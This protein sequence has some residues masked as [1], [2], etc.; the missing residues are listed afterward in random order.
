VARFERGGAVKAGTLEAIQRTLEK[1]GVIYMACSAGGAIKIKSASTS[2]TPA[3]ILR[4]QPVR[5]VG[6]HLVDVTVQ[7]VRHEN[8]PF[9]PRQCCAIGWGSNGAVLLHF[10]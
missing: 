10:G 1:A 7:A 2:V 4:G 3:A 6:G 5:F 8:S 9:G